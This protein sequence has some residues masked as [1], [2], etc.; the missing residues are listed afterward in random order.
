M[1]LKHLDYLGFY[2]AFSYGDSFRYQTKLGG[3][4]S[5]ILF[6]LTLS[7]IGSMGSQL[8]DRHDPLIFQQ[9]QHFSYP[10]V[11]K[12]DKSFNIAIRMTSG[13][14]N[15]FENLDKVRIRLFLNYVYKSNYNNMTSKEI[16]L[17]SCKKDKFTDLEDFYEMYNLSET[18]CPN[19]EEGFIS[20]DILST[21]FYFYQIKF[22]ICENDPLTGKSNDGADVVCKSS[23]EIE[24]FLKDNLVKAHIFFPDTYFDEKNYSNPSINYI[25]NYNLNIYYESQRETHIF[26]KHMN[27]I[28][29]DTY[30]F[31][32]PIVRNFQT[33]SFSSI[34]E[35]AAVREHQMK[36]YVLI[37]LRSDKVSQNIQRSY[38][39]FAEIAA[40][41]GAL[42]NIVFIFFN[43]ILFLI[44]KIEFLNQLFTKSNFIYIKQSYSNDK[45]LRTNT[46]DNRKS[47]AAITDYGRL[48]MEESKSNI[49]VNTSTPQHG[50]ITES[51]WR[52]ANQL[53]TNESLNINKNTLVKGNTFENFKYISNRFN[54]LVIIPPVRGKSLFEI[55]VLALCPCV[56]KCNKNIRKQIKISEFLWD[57]FMKYT[58]FFKFVKKFIEL[59][60]IKKLILSKE[61]KDVVDI[62]KKL[63]F[64]KDNST[65]EMIKKNARTD[66]RTKN[67]GDNLKIKGSL[68]S[69][70][71]KL[72]NYLISIIQKDN[73]SVFE[74]NLL[75]FVEEKF[76][77]SH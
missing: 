17:T 16:K 58:D 32:N 21:E 69:Q 26:L 37:N 6:I 55:I 51:N 13:H 48:N 19:L 63:I 46:K 44:S 10:P 50:L 1:N 52:K 8:F 3:A 38:K 77:A 60:I 14:D 73:K 61:E 49:N 43:G 7:I 34:N 68:L 22:S 74:K 59:E 40:N 36:D 29:D 9:I 30:F 2:F 35:R 76:K 56:R 12:F 31:L 47:A 53:N 54:S 11:I 33:I 42:V 20:G 15:L 62:L 5:S 18:M 25:N 41:T 23:G 67:L 72:K 4:L 70:E 75:E 71:S 65:T 57:Q 64:L 27:L 39:G 66:T 24:T 45:I 28:S